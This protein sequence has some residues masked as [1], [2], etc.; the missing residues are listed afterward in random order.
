[1]VEHAMGEQAIVASEK[2]NIAFFDASKFF[3]A[4]AQ[5]VLWKNAGQHAAAEDPE[6]CGPG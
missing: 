3:A 1:M 2:D 6:A 4:N 5:D